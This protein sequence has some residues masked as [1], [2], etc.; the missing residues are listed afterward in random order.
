MAPGIIGPGLE[1]FKSY[2]NVN[3]Y[4]LI[5]AGIESEIVKMGIRKRLLFI[6]SLLISGVSN[7]QLMDQ[8]QPT[9]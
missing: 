3:N 2:C 5:C 8:I 1:Q 6:Y 4:I 9:V 7:L